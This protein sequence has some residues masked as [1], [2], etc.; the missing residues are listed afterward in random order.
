MKNICRYK[1]HICALLALAMLFSCTIQSASAAWDLG[2]VSNPLSTLQDKLLLA[3]DRPEAIDPELISEKGHIERLYDKESSLEMVAFS[4]YDG[5]ETVYIFDEPIKYVDEMGR[6]VDKSNTLYSA[7]EE[8]YAY[9]NSDNNIRTYFPDA[10]NENS[11][12][13]LKYED[14]LI[15]LYPYEGNTAFVQKRM[16]S[17]D[18]EYT[19]Y[20]GVFGEDTAVRYTP[21]FSGFKEEIILY[22]NTENCFNFI[23]KCESLT[24]VVDGNQVC[25]IDSTTNEVVATLGRVYLYDSF[26]GTS[27]GFMHES[28]SNDTE[29]VQLENGDYLVT[30]TVDEY[31]LNHP[32]TVYPVYVDPTITINASGS[33]TS[34]TI[35]DTP[36]YNGSGVTNMTAGANASAT[37]G[38]VGT[39]SGVQ[40]G[41]G[42]LLMK[43]PGLM[44]QSF[45]SNYNYTITSATLYL[46]DTSGLSTSATI[47]AYMYTG[48]SWTESS[49]YSSAIWNGAGEELSSYTYS[50]P[51]STNGSFNITKAVKLWQSLP[52]YGAKGIILK[53]ITSESSLSYY[54]SLNTTEGSTKPYLSVSYANRTAASKAFLTY[55]ASSRTISIRL[56]GSTTTSSPWLSIITDSR[57]A[58]N[59][60]GAGTNIS[61]TTTGSSPHTL[62]VESLPT[63][64]W[65]GLMTPTVS[66]STLT[67]SKIQINMYQ[68]P[69]STNFGRSTV[70][71][72]MGHLLWLN[73]NPVTT[74]PCLMRH[75]RD[76]EIVFVP[77]MVDIFHVRSKY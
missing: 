21:T 14:I 47:E 19:F 68:L 26:I 59:N 50:Y 67:A 16:G 12:I 23:L 55:G 27:E 4:N 63:E 65:Y 43:F 44:N 20:D 39:Q 70:T 54:K 60:S 6:I 8:N 57:T 66:G 49:K 10:L 64:T 13:M 76:R 40:Y 5:T 77:Q 25:L 35:L 11:G 42:R 1:N 51:N 36:I 62:T 71:H 41:A 61:T 2:N 18:V 22:D 53:N 56:V 24:P 69:A 34:K 9:V 28:W 72:E 52:E 48:P 30:V 3:D 32:E 37:V 31:F 15:E 17:N 46:K 38:Y 74:D 75:D 73:D 7:Y 33:G 58:W 45:M 29:I